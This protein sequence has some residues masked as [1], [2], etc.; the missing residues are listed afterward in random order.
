MQAAAVAFA[1][2]LGDGL[3]SESAR[4]VDYPSWEDVLAARSNEASKQGEITRIRGLIAGLEAETVA[5]QALSEQRGAE[6]E[7]AQIAFDEGM[8]RSDEL[9]GKAGEATAEAQASSQ[10]A[11]ALAAQL[12]RSGGSD[13]SVALLGSSGGGDVDALLYQL[14]AL[15]KLTEQ[16]SQIYELAAQSRNSAA[17]LASQAAMAK[18][19][20]DVL[21]VA[22]EQALA[23]AAAAQAAVETMLAE[24]QSRRVEL[25]VQLDVLV[26]NRAATEADYQAGVVERARIAEEQARAEREARA[27]AERERAARGGSGGSGGGGGSPGGSPAPI[28]SGPGGQGW[29]NPLPNARVS[30]EFGNRFHPIDAVWRLHAGIDLV[31]PGGTCGANVYAASAGTVTFAGSNGG[32]GNAV[33]INHG[34]GRTTVY[35]HNTPLVVRSGWAV[36]EGQL[37]AK[38]GTTGAS[39][40]CHV[41][42]E[43]R[44][45]GTAENPR[46]VLAQYGTGF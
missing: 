27:A 36:A 7:T 41:H 44:L 16:T 3:A 46:Q 19:A 11:G 28:V 34:G 25:A 22:A 37:I 39:T 14:G 8:R 4:A 42:F 40:G 1:L 43:T 9:E 24:E 5:A 20:L 23:E 38:A 12:A 15:S 18:S 21:R 6:Y 2:V 32:L 26:S 45:N 13:L 29:S 31:S 17:A 35:G 30:S 33:T 10:R